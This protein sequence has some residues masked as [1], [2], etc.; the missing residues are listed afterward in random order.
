MSLLPLSGMLRK[1]HIGA[2]ALLLGAAGWFG[3]ATGAEQRPTPDRDDP[4]EEVGTLECSLIGKS[5][6]T[7][8][9][10][11]QN[12][13]CVFRPGYAGPMET[14]TG[15]VQGVGKTDLLFGRGS[16]LLVVKA[17]MS[18]TM[19]PGLLAQRYT[20]DAAASGSAAPPLFGDQNKLIVMYPLM[21]QPGRVSE[22]KMQPDAI[23]I[24]VELSLESTPA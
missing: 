23:I 16:V 24:V 15:S 2:L 11:G 18:T 3:I 8:T 9:G 12:V 21:E 19:R 14:Y 1:S 10:I 13:T 7:S 5:D 4:V 6:G 22:G 20:A 17:P